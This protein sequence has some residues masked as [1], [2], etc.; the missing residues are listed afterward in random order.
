[1][2]GNKSEKVD[3]T[4]F[5]RTATSKAPT[6][7]P[8]LTSYHTTLESGLNLNFIVPVFTAPVKFRRKFSKMSAQGRD[9]MLVIVDSDCSRL[10]SLEETLY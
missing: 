10:I 4:S 5:T 1:M 3:F 8:Y 2:K 7:L 9:R 6:C